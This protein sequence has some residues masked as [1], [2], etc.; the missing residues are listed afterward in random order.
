MFARGH[1]LCGSIRFEVSEPP[2]RMRQCHCEDCRRSSGTGHIVQA[3]FN[4]D[5]VSISGQ[6]HAFSNTAD[7]G[8]LRTRHFCPKCGSRLF[9][10]N[11]AAPGAM[12][13][14]VGVFDDTKWFRPEMIVYFG[15]CASWDV[16]DPTIETRE[17]M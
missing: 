12:G 6:T 4:R 8:N 17:K 3:F 14:S 10:E 9:T 7:S 1:C 13:I 11:A 2:V 5:A 16:V 15:Q